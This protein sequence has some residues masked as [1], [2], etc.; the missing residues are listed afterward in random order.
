MNIVHVT[1]SRNYE[2]KIGAGLLARAGEEIRAVSGAKRA[3][4]VSD[5]TV[6]GLYGETLKN[7]L[8]AAGTDCAE[9]VFPHGEQSK[10]LATYE[11]LL[12]FLCERHLTRKDILVALG[13]GV[14]GDL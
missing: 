5:D 10:T 3:V 8:R 6:F 12:T 11:K 1:S 7:S 9:F 4:I 14:T 13:G 2:I